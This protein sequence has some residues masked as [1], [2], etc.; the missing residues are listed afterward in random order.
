MNVAY[1]YFADYPWDVRVEKICRTLAGAGHDVHIIARNKAWSPLVETRSEGTVHRLPPWKALGR[2]LDV[3][4][5]FPAFA[6]PRWI[7]HT[8]RVAEQTNAEVLIVRDLPLAPTAVWVGRALGVPVVIDMAEN[9]PAFWR[10][11]WELGRRKPQD[12]LLRNPKL[13]AAVERW[14][15]PRADKIL[16]V[17]EENGERLQRMGVD[18]DDIVLVSNTPPAA[19]ALQPMRVHQ[20]RGA[21]LELSYLGVVEVSRGLDLAVEAVAL[22]RD[23]GHAVH[24][25]VVGYGRDVEFCRGRAR[26]LGLGDR[27]VTFHGYVPH[28]RALEL[29][30]RADVGL[31]PHR[32][33]E[34][35]NTTI[36]NKIFDYMAA[37]LPVVTADAVPFARIVRETGAG[38]VFASGRTDE[39]A[40]AVERFLDPEERERCGLA[41]RRAVIAKYNWERDAERLLECIEGLA[42]PAPGAAAEPALASR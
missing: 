22:L 20:E 3:G 11:N 13:I 8:R 6:S 10:Q 7:A 40:R 2:K 12:W 33:H 41:G 31:L 42:A 14:C 37:G 26:D 1:L 36:P 16:V 25:D 34:M 17:V 27:E 35:W 5:S 28:E 15:V 38:E 39:L 30:S 29:V 32:T 24:L 18:R 19:K 23:R 9:Y 21:P 4:L